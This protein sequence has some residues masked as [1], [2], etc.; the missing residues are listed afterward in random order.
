MNKTPDE[1]EILA[2]LLGSEANRR[3]AF[4][5]IFKKSGWREWVVQHVRQHD[6]DEQMGE[7]VFQE[8]TILFDRNLREGRFR[9]ESSVRTY[10]FGIAKQHWFN[11]RR[12]LRKIEALENQQF[13]DVQG[14][15]SE[16]IFE[17]EERRLTVES[18]L[19][20]IGEHC[21]RVLALYKLSFSNEEIARE[22][23]LSSPELAKK[24]AYRCREKFREFVVSRPDLVAFFNLKI[25][26]G[27]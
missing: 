1:K 9:G 2:A 21:Q 27:K 8:T 6:G 25:D 7:D 14:E 3:E 19:Q 15:S 18:I 23:G 11:R 20:A 24:Y 10:F 26:N 4:N 16:Q 13:A 17:Q 12:S 22:L 5:W